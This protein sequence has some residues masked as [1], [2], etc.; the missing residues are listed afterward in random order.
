MTKL[1]FN[2]R[3]GVYH[4][5]WGPDGWSWTRNPY[6]ERQKAFAAN[7]KRFEVYRAF[8]RNW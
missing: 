5:Q 6:Q 1:W 2:V 8:G 4:F 7:W 3:F